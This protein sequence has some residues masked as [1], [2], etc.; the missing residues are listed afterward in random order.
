MTITSV[1]AIER[2]V[3]KANV[4]LAD[5]DAELG[6]DN[7]D[8][9]WRVLRAYL[10]S[11]R[12]HLTIEEGAHFAAQLPHLL[13]GVFY[14][15]FRPSAV[16]QR[17]RDREAFLRGFADAASLSGPTDAS[18]AA[19]ALTRV[20]RRHVSEGEVDEVLGQMPE[21]VRAVLEHR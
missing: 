20:L 19:E 9:A 4:W 5:V 17:P 15:G 2:S 11:L 13:R 12:D 6:R 10:H 14:E 1:D 3:Q 8:E 21:P 18:M 16:R 7:R